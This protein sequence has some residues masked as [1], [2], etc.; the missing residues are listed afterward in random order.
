[1]PG[2]QY[3]DRENMR[4]NQQIPAHSVPEGRSGGGKDSGGTPNLRANPESPATS[5]PA[6]ASGSNSKRLPFDTYADR[7]V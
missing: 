4:A 2:T 6:P 5:I 1:M 7:T 3:N